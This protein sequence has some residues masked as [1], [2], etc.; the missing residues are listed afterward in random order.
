MA[1]NNG[2]RRLLDEYVALADSPRNQ[3]LLHETWLRPNLAYIENVGVPREGVVPIVAD[4]MLAMWAKKM[5][6]NVA[7]MYLEPETCLKVWLSREIGRFTQIQ[8]DR[9]LNKR[10]IVL[11]GAGFESSMFGAKQVYSDDTDPW[12]DRTP[13]LQQPDDLDRLKL[14]DFNSSGMMPLA[15]RFYNEL[16]ELVKQHGLTIVFPNWGRSPFAVAMALCGMQQLLVDMIEQ[17]EFVEKL[18]VF[19]TQSAIHYR[20]ARA[21]FLGMAL[22]QPEL[23]NDE[24]NVPSI[25]PR[26]YRDLVLPSEKAYASA[27]GGLMYWHSCGNV[28]PMLELIREIPNITIFHVGPWTD[29]ARA[30]GIFGDTTLDICLHSMDVYRATEEAMRAKVT[31]IVQTCWQHGARSFSIRPGILEAFATVDEDLAS[32]AR[33]VRVAKETVAHLTSQKAQS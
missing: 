24:V 32:A 15:H 19:L 17:P 25:S 18:L 21:K 30:A 22:D 11:L 13:V 1:K 7:E 14:P 28:T 29:V 8:D 27:F 4:P 2:I 33:W 6:I 10:M 16:S 12:I 3:K 20:Q 5:G 9:P 26:L 31:T 23:G